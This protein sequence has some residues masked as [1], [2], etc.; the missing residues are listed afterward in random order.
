MEFNFSE[1]FCIGVDRNSPNYLYSKRAVL[2]EFGFDD[3]IN[4]Y[5]IE[6]LTSV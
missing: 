4:N 3:V 5:S 2:S 1:R 6:P